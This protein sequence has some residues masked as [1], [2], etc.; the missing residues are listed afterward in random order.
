MIRKLTA[1]ALLMVLTVGTMQAEQTEGLTQLVRERQVEEL[2][3]AK[4]TESELSESDLGPRIQS[5]VERLC[6]QPLDPRDV[7][8]MSRLGQELWR[9]VTHAL[10]SDPGD[11]WDDRDLYW[12][13]LAIKARLRSEAIS[14]AGRAGLAAFE[15]SSRGFEDVQFADSDTFR[16]VVTGFDPFHL[17]RHLDQSNPSGLA[18]IALD[19]RQLETTVGYARVETAVFPVRFADFD[20]GMVEDFIEPVLQHQRPD[21][22]L[23]I[24]MGRDAFDLERFPGRRRSSAVTDN[25]N[26]LTGANPAEPLIPNL[27]GVPLDGPEFL[28]FT[29][30]AA[31]M[32]AVSGSFPVR[33]NR[34]VQ[35]LASGEFEA[36]SLAAL[37]GE[38]AVA[39]S[40]GGYLSNEISYRTLLVNQRQTQAQIPMG[41]LH[42]PRVEGFDADLEQQ[43]LTQIERILIAAIEASLLP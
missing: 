22:V 7:G 9:S 42:T 1:L 35:T 21:L 37:H 2:R 18:A 24:S 13:R 40:G 41:H 15:R 36:P 8:A 3:L 12:A 4:F 30:P 27:R 26:I 19:G 38:I 5:L 29:L 6:A 14:D 34:R 23:T 11:S 28:E 25:L 39:G 17:D 32:S 16:V 33:D 10:Q 31:A 20:Q 43:I